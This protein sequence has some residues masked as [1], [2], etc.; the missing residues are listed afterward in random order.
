[1]TNDNDAAT[2][3]SR[4]QFLQKAALTVIG[5]GIAAT[6]LCRCQTEA[7]AAGLDD[8]GAKP[9]PPRSP[10]VKVGK[11]SD[12]KVGTKKSFAGSGFEIERRG[13]KI[14]AISLHCTH[15][16][17]LINPSSKGFACPAHG[18]QFDKDG[19][20]TNGPAQTNLPWYS[21]TLLKTGELEVDTSK[22]VPLGT[23]FDVKK[24]K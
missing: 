6:G 5:A 17:V 19:R 8:D 9:G 22:V 20:V 16:G 23:S 11:L 1:M 14:V 7:A 24:K 15:K 13:D 12:F 3:E 18:A 2:N 21:V 4:R 10:K